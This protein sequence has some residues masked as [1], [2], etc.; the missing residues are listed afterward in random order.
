[1]QIGD[2]TSFG[3][4]VQT[5]TATYPVIVDPRRTQEV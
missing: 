5:Y 1:V 4:A 3:R 2:H